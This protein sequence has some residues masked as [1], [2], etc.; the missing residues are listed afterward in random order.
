MGTVSF[1]FVLVDIGGDFNKTSGKFTAPKQGKYLFMVDGL[2]HY[3]R[4]S[5]GEIWIN[6]NGEHIKRIR[7]RDDS[8]NTEVNGIV[9]TELQKGDVVT[10]FIGYDN[11]IR[12][13]GIQPFTFIG[14]LLS[15]I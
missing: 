7:E 8:Y 11:V 6:V 14:T 5:Y 9:V 4:S 15:E 1:D 12:G 10:V 2:A 3:G 13:D